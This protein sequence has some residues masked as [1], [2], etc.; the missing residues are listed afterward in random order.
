MKPQVLLAVVLS[1]APF[2][3]ADVSVGDSLAQVQAALGRPTG[4]MRVGDRQRLYFER[5]SVEL[6]G[7]RVTQVSLRT[8]AEQAAMDAR[9]ERLRAEHETRRAG[10]VAE[11]TALRDRKLADATFSASPVAYQVAFWEDFARRYPG[12]PCV[13]PLTIARLKLGEQ[14]EEK[15]R[16]AEDAR[17]IADLEERLAAAEQ[18]RE[19]YRIRSYP[20]YGYRQQEFAL[21]PV[22]YT[23]YDAPL[24]AYTTPTLPSVN[25]F[26]GDPAQPERRDYVRG[27][28]G[29]SEDC[30]DWRDSRGRE[31]G[32]G[33]GRGRWR[34]RM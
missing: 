15:A 12:V 8:P 4:Q 21:W 16:K 28:S 2:G 6:V 10:L 9:E 13:E 25:P 17:R 11:G 31:G 30:G 14:L 7:S 23:Y 20:R 18:P 19:Y 22:R 24:P 29:R 3:I 32:R 1:A 27:G 33:Q 26:V 5:G 34:D